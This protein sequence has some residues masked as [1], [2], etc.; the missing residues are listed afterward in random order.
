MLNFL[1]WYLTLTLLGLFT[2]PLVYRFFPKFADRGYS[3][4]RAIGLLL[5]GYIFWLLTSLGIAQNNL[6]GILLGLAI[7]GGGT[8]WALNREEGRQEILAWL[9]EHARLIATV[10]ILFFFS[11]IALALLRASNP[12]ALGTEKPMELAFINAILRSPAF[13]PRDPW[14]SGYAISYYHF[15]YIMAAMLAKVTATAGS[16]A[17]NL[18][19]ALIFALSASGA[20]GILYNLLSLS[21]KAIPEKEEEQ[22]LTKHSLRQKRRISASFFS[23]P[24]TSAPT[25]SALLAP[26]FLLLVSNFEALLEIIH[27]TG[28]FWISNAPNFWTWLNIKNLNTDPATQTPIPQRFWWWWRASRVIQ[29]FDLLGNHREVIDEFPFFSFLL[30][31]L[32]PHLLSLPFALLAVAVALYIFIGGWRGKTTLFKFRFDLPPFAIFGISLLL[33]GLAFLNTWDILPAATLITAAY[34]LARVRRKG[35]SWERLEDFLYFGMLS[36]TAAIFLYLPFY[37]GFASQAGGILPNLINPTR[38]AHLWI[39]FGTLLI[40]L[41]LW[42]FSLM[43]KNISWTRTRRRPPER[44]ESASNSTLRVNRKVGFGLVFG[45]LIALWAFSWLTAWAATLARPE[46]A[47]DL[48]RSQGVGNLSELFKRATSLRIN[49]FAGIFT[50]FLVTGGAV[51]LLFFSKEPKNAE[52]DA[53]LARTFV[54]L[55]IVLGSLLVIAPEFFY[56]RDQFGTRMNTIFKFYY[57]A[58]LL[59]SL[60]AAYASVSLLKK[61]RGYQIGLGL[62]IAAALIY[63]VFGVMSKQNPNTPLTLDSAAHLHPDEAA[64]V[65]WLQKAPDGVLL[66]A[67]GGS[68][69]GYARISTYSGLPTVL[70]WPGHESQW[71]G[72]Y[73]EMGT[74][75]QDIETMYTSPDWEQTKELLARYNVRYVIVG[76]L[77]RSTYRVDERKFQR[78]LTPAFSQGEITV[79]LVP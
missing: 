2:F 35:W 18:M 20:Y 50:L 8:A 78:Y 12:E 3:F 17:F 7:V 9:K 14:L 32:H 46:L 13:P 61:G 28:L 64:A 44:A 75:Q 73:E 6:G 65:A 24:A 11:F 45:L 54:L 58:W 15:G 47:T 53:G 71:R 43:P 41:F 55:M 79:Y 63:P 4:S 60:A 38:G 51:T 37:L 1:S 67:V 68:Y 27:Q 76:G 5:W 34:T 10:E 31:D 52:Q 23:F 57:Q 69:T 70:G 48:I 21:P 19:T 16:V 77:E 29:D 59:W 56:L 36:G 26:L 42:I 62:V 33:G 40:P 72:G 30:G 25:N 39:M 22:E 74:R 49:Y 66:E